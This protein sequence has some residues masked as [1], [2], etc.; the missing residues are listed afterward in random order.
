MVSALGN[1]RFRI[2]DREM[3]DR[4]ALVR[5]INDALRY[6]AEKVILVRAEAGTYYSDFIEMVD[7]IYHPDELV[8][9]YTDRMLELERQGGCATI[10]GAINGRPNLLPDSLIPNGLK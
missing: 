7:S 3:P 9:I 4:A 2:D 6:R 1:H 10:R 5:G 8:A